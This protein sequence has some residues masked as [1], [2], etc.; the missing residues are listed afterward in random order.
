MMKN[1]PTVLLHCSSVPVGRRVTTVFQ[2]LP[3][4]ITNN[5]HLD[6]WCEN[7][8]PLTI[9]RNTFSHGKCHTDQNVCKSGGYKQAN[10]F[11]VWTLFYYFK[12]KVSVTVI[13]F[14]GRD[15]INCEGD[16]RDKNEIR[17]IILFKLVKIHLHG[18]TILPLG[19]RV[20]R[21]LRVFYFPWKRRFVPAFF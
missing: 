2:T 8:I 12:K 1:A 13:R 20:S 11:S 5:L 10:I 16:G 3:A 6:I 14:V 17:F 18:R 15:P 21:Q 4:G 9:N 19:R 7:L